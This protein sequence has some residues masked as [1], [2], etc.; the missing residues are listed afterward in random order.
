[1]L[2]V[3]SETLYYQSLTNKKKSSS[4]EI[5][6]DIE[7]IKKSFGVNDKR[8]QIMEDYLVK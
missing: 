1:M 2:D 7:L 5:A 4:K 6:K 3:I 8:V